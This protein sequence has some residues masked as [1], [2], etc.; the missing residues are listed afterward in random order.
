MDDARIGALRSKLGIV[1]WFGQ[2]RRGLSSKLEAWSV[3]LRASSV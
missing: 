2:A 1:W 3:E